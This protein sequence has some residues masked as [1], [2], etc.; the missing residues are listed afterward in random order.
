[1]N[2]KDCPAISRR[3]EQ[4]SLDRDEQ[5]DR[6]LLTRIAARDK[7]ALRTFF[8]RHQA[9]VHGFLGRI[10]RSGESVEENVIETFV[11]AWHEAHTFRGGSRVAIWLLRI[12]YRLRLA[13]QRSEVA[14]SAGPVG[15]DFDGGC[16][17]MTS[18]P[19]WLSQSLAQLSF[20]QRAVVELVY[21]LGLSCDEIAI[22]MQCSTNAV[23][24]RVLR[25]RRNLGR[26]GLKT[27]HLELPPSN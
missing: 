13:S 8:L 4:I 20:R 23:K 1:M 9:R 6:D 11:A 12:A 22:V 25:A 24:A 17:E 5:T 18:K 3:A 10:R 21:G 7:H 15:A 27:A 14:S 26:S 19:G 2:I 16:S